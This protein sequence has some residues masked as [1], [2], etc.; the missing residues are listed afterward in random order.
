MPTTKWT[1]SS[2]PATLLNLG[3]STTDCAGGGGSYASCA[4]TINAGL[5]NTRTYMFETSP[6]KITSSFGLMGSL[7]SF[8]Y[9]IVKP[10]W[11]SGATWSMVVELVPW[12]PSTST[13]GTPFRLD[14][15]SEL[16]NQ[17]G[18]ATCG[19]WQWNPYTPKFDPNPGILSGE[20]VIRIT[21]TTTNTNPSTLN[22]LR[23]DEI[24]M[25][26]TILDATDAEPN[27]L[28]E[29]TY[30]TSVG[31][32]SINSSGQL[33]ANVVLSKSA[34]S[35]V[36]CAGGGGVNPSLCSLSSVEGRHIV[37][38]E[39]K[40]TGD[41][42]MVSSTAFSIPYQSGT[43]D[44]TVSNAV[45]EDPS[46]KYQHW[47]EV[48]EWNSGGTDLESAFLVATPPTKPSRTLSI[49]YTAGQW[50]ATLSGPLTDNLAIRDFSVTGYEMPQERGDYCDPSLAI[51]NDGIWPEI[52][53]TAGGTTATQANNGLSCNSYKKKVGTSGFV[54]NVSRSNGASF[55]FKGHLLTLNVSGTTCSFYA[56]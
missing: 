46:Y 56:C 4:S 53:I 47:F 40:A 28:S 10:A 32:G 11:S 34:Q 20:Y 25:D 41:K 27:G 18:A 2:N 21:V 15:G 22:C 31:G 13:Y 16:T 49:G 12:N 35:A 9:S 23:F 45:H 33:I 44:Y 3:L 42:Q 43:W 6:V 24:V 1:G 36:N 55:D 30:S 38:R 51:E 14:N 19:T 50:T 5:N 26:W 17:T 7:T 52:V 29:P 8:R 54:D 37:I 48:Q 39:S